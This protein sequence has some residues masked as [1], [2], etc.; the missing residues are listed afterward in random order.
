[1]TGS[2]ER[3]ARILRAT[4]ATLLVIG[5]GHTAHSLGGGSG[6]QPVAVVVLAALVAP[7]VWALVRRRAS[8]PRMALAMGAGQLVTHLSLVAMAPGRGAATAPHVHGAPA[9]TA[10]DAVASASAAG[11]GLAATLHL[12]PGMVAAHALA[13]VLAAVVLSRGADA[14]RAVVRALLP[15]HPRTTDVAGIPCPA[16]TMPALLVP[17]GRAVRP[18]GGRGP[19]LPVT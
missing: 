13:T 3:A 2:Q 10:S 1:M 7:V 9:V 15:A 4:V 6:P 12:T 11:T 16:A 18:V 8:A 5:L 17:T 19:P 14:V